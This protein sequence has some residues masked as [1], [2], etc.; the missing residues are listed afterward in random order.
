MS[1]LKNLITFV[2]TKWWLVIITSIIILA[3][4]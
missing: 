3:I 2:I 1:F 4:V